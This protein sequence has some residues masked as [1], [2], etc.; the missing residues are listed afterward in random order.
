MHLII[1]C[2][3]NME[4]PFIMFSKMGPEV[5][6]I[7]LGRVRVLLVPYMCWCFSAR[8]TMVWILEGR[9]GGTGDRYHRGPSFTIFLRPESFSNKL[10]A[11]ADPNCNKKGGVF[12]YDS[13]TSM[14]EI[15]G[16]QTIFYIN[17]YVLVRY[18]LFNMANLFIQ[19]WK[20]N[21]KL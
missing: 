9:G 8:S 18:F 21:I 5:H 17:L 12:M 10:N 11:G 6:F 20:D 14:L 7:K 15:T 4:Y 16:F 13:C 19:S 1:I 3:E 2:K